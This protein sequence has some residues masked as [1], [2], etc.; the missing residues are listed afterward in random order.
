MPPIY[1]WRLKD[2]REVEVMR[3]LEEYEQPPTKE[4]LARENL[5]PEEAEGAERLIGKGIQTTRGASWSGSK[6]NWANS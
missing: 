4:E 1:T 6:G 5:T 3:S 2:G